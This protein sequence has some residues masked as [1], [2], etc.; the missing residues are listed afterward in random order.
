[1]NL[2]CIFF[3]LYVRLFSHNKN[4]DISNKSKET[5]KREAKNE[6]MTL[7]PKINCI[8]GKNG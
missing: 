3:M 1:M 6:I 7:M 8:N 2:S 5:R 4:T